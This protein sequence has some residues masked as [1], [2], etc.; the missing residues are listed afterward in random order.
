V[1]FTETG[2]VTLNLAGTGIEVAYGGVGD[3]VLSAVGVSGAVQLY[4]LDGADQLIGGDGND[5]LFF[6]SADTLLLGG[7]GVDSAAVFFTETGDVTLNLA[8][9]GIEVAYGGVGDDV[10]SAAG[11]SG[12]VQLYG[13][14]GADQLIGGDGNDVLFFDSADTLLQGGAGVDSAA[15]FFTETGDVTLN[16][17]G[18]GIEVAYGGVGDD[19]IS[20]AGMTDNTRLEGL[21][22]ADT[23]TGGDANDAIFG[24]A[25]DDVI[26]ASAGD[27]YLQ[28]DA[29]TDTVN[30]AGDMDDFTITDIGGGFFQVTGAG[31]GTHTLFQVEV[32]HFND[33]NLIL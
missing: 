11:V 7:A 31:I 19:T 28:G 21:G 29:G 12:A 26:F 30:Y 5:V 9:T 10:L 4:G 33:G 22:G 27:D 32:L 23:L 17:A 16:L 3:D 13:L 6:D 1:F 18:T 14:D 2:D 24:G 15:V 8:G 25:G 20:A